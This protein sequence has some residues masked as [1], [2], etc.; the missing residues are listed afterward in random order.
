MLRLDASYELMTRAVEH[1]LCSRELEHTF[2]LIMNMFMCICRNAD[3]SPIFDCNI[4]GLRLVA[5]AAK[6]AWKM[7]TLLFV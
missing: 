1:I 7:F 5:G 6:H 3:F 4:F 2:N